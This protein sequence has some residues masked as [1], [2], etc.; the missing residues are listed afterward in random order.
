L[1]K[2]KVFSSNFALSAASGLETIETSLIIL[3]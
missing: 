3:A 1:T 2:R